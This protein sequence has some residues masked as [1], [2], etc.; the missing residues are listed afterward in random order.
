LKTFDKKKDADAFA[1]TAKVEIRESV[2]VADSAS[3]TVSF[4]CS[5]GWRDRSSNSDRPTLSSLPD[6]SDAG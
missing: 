2:H 3:V 1:A 5:P 6:L 4:T